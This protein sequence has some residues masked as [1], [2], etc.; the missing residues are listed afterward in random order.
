MNGRLDQA[1]LALLIAELFLACAIAV[2]MIVLIL[3]WLVK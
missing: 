1:I 3:H 2:L